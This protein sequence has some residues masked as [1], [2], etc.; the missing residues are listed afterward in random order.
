M[1]A[2]HD[3]ADLPQASAN[4]HPIDHM[5]EAMCPNCAHLVDA[6][7][8]ACGNHVEEASPD[9]LKLFD[10]GGGVRTY[11]TPEEF[12]R[13]LVLMIQSA[14][15]SKF[16]AGCYLIASGSGFADGVS[17]TEFGRKWG[18]GKAAVS[19]NCKQICKYL[20][21]PPSEKYMRKEATAEKFRTSNR[22]PHKT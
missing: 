20:G 14:R 10:V 11:L 6:V 18:V 2:N 3:A 4:D 21:I 9:D 7:C 16:T 13:R 12:Y 5:L 22:R 19:K 1:T 8:P 17:M 15:N